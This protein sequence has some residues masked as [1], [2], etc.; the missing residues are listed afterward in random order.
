MMNSDTNSMPHREASIPLTMLS[1]P[2]L[3]PMVRS[4]AKYIGAARPPARSSRASSEDSPWPFRP[5]IR[6]W[7]PSGDWMVAR[8]MM[9]FSS[10]K[11]CTGTSFSTPSTIFFS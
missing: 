1:A 5:V 8:L 6:N 9:R 2:R 4:S 7:L 11:V 3:G 10:L